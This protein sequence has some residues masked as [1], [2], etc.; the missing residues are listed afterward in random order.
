M[1]N[2]DV[3]VYEKKEEEP[4][5]IATAA[6]RTDLHV[7]VPIC[8]YQVLLQCL[9]IHNLELVIVLPAPEGTPT[10]TIFS[11]ELTCCTKKST[12]RLRT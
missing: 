1:V 3:I 9:H 5:E 4:S 6:W 12:R 11:V 7:K 2:A 10:L 8:F